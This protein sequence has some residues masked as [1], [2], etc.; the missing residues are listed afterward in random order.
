MKKDQITN[1]IRKNN[2]Q[3]QISNLEKDLKLID[4]KLYSMK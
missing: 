4:N 3:K 2:L 1:Q